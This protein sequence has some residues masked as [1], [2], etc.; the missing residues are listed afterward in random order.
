MVRIFIFTHGSIVIF[1]EIYVF[2]YYMISNINACVAAVFRTGPVLNEG[3]LKMDKI[4]DTMKK[5]LKVSDRGMIWNT[6]LVEALELENLMLNGMQTIQGAAARE[7][8]C[9]FLSRSLKFIPIALFAV[10]NSILQALLFKIK[11]RRVVVHTLGRIFRSDQMNLIIQSLWLVK[12]ESRWR[13]TGAST[14][15]LLKIPTPER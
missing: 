1:T 4:F 13:S 5:D 8:V 2:E 3:T 6:D 12:H 7:E 9:T 10:L 11:F 15:S 14:P